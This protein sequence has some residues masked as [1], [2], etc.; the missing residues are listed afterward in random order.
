MS[1][2]LPWVVRCVKCGQIYFFTREI[3]NDH[4]C[5]IDATFIDEPPQL[6]EKGGE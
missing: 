3:P 1:D 6:P 5:V 4:V 2:D